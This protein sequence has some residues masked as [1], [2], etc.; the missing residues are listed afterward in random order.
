MIAAVRKGGTKE[1]P[2][3][4]PPPLGGEAFT[5][6]TKE[7][8]RN[9]GP[10]SIESDHGMGLLLKEVEIKGVERRFSMSRYR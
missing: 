4:R 9:S 10:P 8:S 1:R 2:T 6:S 5:F 7:N 3:E